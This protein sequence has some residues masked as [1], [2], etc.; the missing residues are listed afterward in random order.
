MSQGFSG[1]AVVKKPLPMQEMWVPS[2][3]QEDP[4][5]E[6]M[7]PPPVL[8][9]AESL[10]RRSLVG[11]SPWGHKESDTTERLSMPYTDSLRNRR[12]SGLASEVSFGSVRRVA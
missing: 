12:D 6:G 9:P 7:Q 4:L 8:L 2:R 10:G 5:E 11:Y 3:D 1:G